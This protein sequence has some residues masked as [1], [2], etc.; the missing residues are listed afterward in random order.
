MRQ[1]TL[2]SRPLASN[3]TLVLTF[4][5]ILTLL[6]SGVLGWLVG[7][8]TLFAYVAIYAI[9]TVFTQR[10][11]AVT[12]YIARRYRN[13]IWLSRLGGFLVLTFVFGFFASVLWRNAAGPLVTWLS[14]GAVIGLAF[15]PERGVKLQLL[16]AGDA[17]VIKGHTRRFYDAVSGTE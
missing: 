17:L 16:K 5:F 11:I 15:N 12:W 7:T 8:A 14:I 2:K 4:G 6:L 13:M 9:V 10:R 3:I 1:R